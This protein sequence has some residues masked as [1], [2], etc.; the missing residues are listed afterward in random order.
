MKIL[1]KI[2]E[3]FVSLSLHKAGWTESAGKFILCDSPL[4]PKYFLEIV[5][6]PCGSVYD[7]CGSIK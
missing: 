5:L 2:E 6:C 1:K 7:N 4:A 3:K